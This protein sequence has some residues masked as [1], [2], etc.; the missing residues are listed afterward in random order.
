[1]PAELV[2]SNFLSQKVTG[3]SEARRIRYERSSMA[4][5]TLNTIG[6]CQSLFGVCKLIYAPKRLRNYSRAAALYSTI[7]L[8]V[9]I[10]NDLVGRISVDG[11]IAAQDF[12]DL[13]RLPADDHATPALGLNPCAERS[14]N[15][16]NAL[17]A[18]PFVHSG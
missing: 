16:A 13:V 5:R 8:R 2:Q 3:K 17:R 4:A 7:D 15:A 12:G 1:M 18:V 10:A 6:G 11:I 14:G 9:L